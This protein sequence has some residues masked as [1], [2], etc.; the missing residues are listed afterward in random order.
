MHW[1]QF[2]RLKRLNMHVQSAEVCLLVEAAREGE[3]LTA[4]VWSNGGN[5]SCPTSDPPVAPCATPEYGCG[6]LPTVPWIAADVSSPPRH[7]LPPP[8][9]IHRH[10]E[11]P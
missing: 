8:V 5:S 11:K 7:L 4:E 10:Q 6:W 3:A 9:G 1:D 2:K